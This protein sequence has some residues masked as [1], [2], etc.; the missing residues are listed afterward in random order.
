MKTKLSQLEKSKKT[1]I[2]GVGT[3]GKWLAANINSKIAGFIDSD[4][5][6]ANEKFD[7]IPVYSP[8]DAQGVLDSNSYV[9][10]TVLDIQDVIE[11]VEALPTDDWVALGCHLNDTKVTFN[12]LKEKSSYVEYALKAVEECHKAYFSKD[13]LFLKAIDVVI[14]ERCSLKC[15]DCSNLMQYYSSPVNISFNEITKDFDQL[16][17]SVDHIYE[18]RLIGGEPFMNKDIYEIVRQLCKEDKINKIVIYTNATIP[19]KNDQLEVLKHP[20]VVFSVTDY[21]N[22][23]RNTSKV[24]GTL[25][26]NKI[27]YRHYPPQNWTDSGVIHDY[28]RS[29]EEMEELFDQCCGK[30][31]LTATDGLLFRCPFAANAHRLKAIPLDKENSVP[32]GSPKSDISHYTSKITHLPACNYCKGRSYDAP[33]IE[34]AIQ[35][36]KPLKYKIYNLV[37]VS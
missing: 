1:Y 15:K 21:G 17:S 32:L 6:K 14:T 26:E 12:P 23:S 36:K 18:L 25:T 11:D 27:P 30:N 31:L 16:L 9:I 2:Y 24:I 37:D 28:K 10:V 29:I 19:L 34:P 20:K 7:G 33:E 3:A 35:T 4:C 8:K 22:L 13:K 5:K